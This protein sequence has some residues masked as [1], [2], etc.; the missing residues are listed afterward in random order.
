MLRG[1]RIALVLLVTGGLLGAACTSETADDEPEAA[2]EEPDGTTPPPSGDNA[3]GDGP[4]AAD[5]SGITDDTIK[6]SLIAS[7][8]AALSE[9]NLAPEIGNAQV[10]LEAIVADINA[11]GGVAGRQLE[12][13]SHVISGTD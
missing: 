8:L 1:T 9:Q 6:I 4:P 3:E 11:N 5:A 13:V 10:T 12:V 7:D 2:A